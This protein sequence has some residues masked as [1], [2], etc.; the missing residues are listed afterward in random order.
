MQCSDVLNK[1]HDSSPVPRYC[2]LLRSAASKNGNIA[3]VYS[4]RFPHKPYVNRCGTQC[5]WND[6]KSIESCK[7]SNIVERAMPNVS[8][9]ER[10]DSKRDLS[11]I[12]IILTS[13]SSRG[14]LPM[15]ISSWRS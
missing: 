12:A 4:L 6:L 2:R 11:N 13:R 5:K 8:D 3:F 9:I 1:I 10:A 14:G 7:C 15:Q